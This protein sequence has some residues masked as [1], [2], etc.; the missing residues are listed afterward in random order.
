MIICRERNAL[1]REIYKLVSEIASK[2]RMAACTA[3][4]GQREKFESLRAEYA[5]LADRLRVLHCCLQLHQEWH[6][7]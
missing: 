7:C 1:Q 6:E 2:S 4:R 5:I 3:R